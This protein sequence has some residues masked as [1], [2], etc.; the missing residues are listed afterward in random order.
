[1]L[2]G[3]RD[4]LGRRTA[5]CRRR[6]LGRLVF[7]VLRIGAAGAKRQHGRRGRHQL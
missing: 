2:Y 5:L 3:W 7:R 4:L 1:M 6:L